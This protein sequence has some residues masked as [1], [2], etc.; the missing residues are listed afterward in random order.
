MARPRLGRVRRPTAGA[1]AALALVLLA[2]LLVAC[3]SGGDAP[4]AAV[5]LV[6]GGR[7][8]TAD[9]KQPWAD[10]LAYDDEGVILA[11]GTE[12][13][14]S[15]QVGEADEV[16][17]L[18]GELVL[19]GFQDAHVHVPEAGINENLCLL[20]PGRDLATYVRLVADCA[21]D[22]PEGQWVRAA[23]ASLFGLR[24][25]TPTPLAALDAAVPDHPVVVLD[26]LGHA[27]WGNTAGL[28]AAG[29]TASTPDPQG[30]IVARDRRTGELTGLLL[31]DAQQPLRN[32]SAP[33]PDEVDAGLR[34]AMDELARNGVTTVS[35]VGGYWQQGHTEAWLRAA[36]ADELTVRAVN[37]LYV[38]PSLG[39]EDQL[40]ELGSRFRDDPDDLL[41]IDTAK[42][43][44]DGILDLGTAQLLA[45]YDDPPDPRFPRGF[46]Y[47]AEEQLTSYVA[48][49]HAMG[50]RISFHVIGDAAVRRAL[51]AVAAIPADRAEVAGR[52]HRLTHTYLV[53]PADVP[54]FAE[55]GVVADFQVGEESTDLAYLDDLSEIIG[56]RAYDLIPVDTLADSGALTILS[57]DWDADLLSPLGIISRALTRETHAL[58]DAETAARMLTIDAAT[59]LGMG[60]R[61]GSLEAGKKADFV[62]LSDDI[63]TLDPAEI[64]D[65]E[66]L[67]TTVDGVEVFRAD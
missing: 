51:D 61:T 63:F 11:V 12:D 25:T 26:D 44:V 54:R 31:E 8:W 33:S 52:H 23:G 22:V 10:A 9:A 1:A 42:I 67:S 39:L 27:A 21:A 46:G 32:A 53:D 5:T 15:R 14:V 49:L 7:I 6:V 64:A 35:D 45:P 66:V 41:Q 36:A 56:D 43:Y 2:T 37:A 16:V 50:F 17:E 59:A 60:D 24:G 28:T 3:S 58:P 29:I 34:V 13:E 48:R 20:P 4:A 65:V 47:F 38:Y 30:G 55:L 18:D 57:S 40:A 62:V 19:P